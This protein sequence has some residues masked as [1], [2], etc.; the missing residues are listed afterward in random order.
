MT[1]IQR[2]TLHV[3]TEASQQILAQPA[4]TR[5]RLNQYVV[6]GKKAKMSLEG[7]SISALDLVSAL[8][9]LPAVCE[10]S[11][12]GCDR[13]GPLTSE[14]LS[15]LHGSCRN[16]KLTK[17]RLPLVPRLRRLFFDF[18]DITFDDVTSLIL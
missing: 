13:H 7:I 4:L 11:I 16:S 18:E 14:F 1:T 2:L 3:E 9:L 5:Y 6:V 12:T 15:S 17:S 8:Y 10:L